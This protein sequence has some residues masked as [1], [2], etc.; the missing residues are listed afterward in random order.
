VRRLT[1]NLRRVGFQ[2]ASTTFV[3]PETISQLHSSWD[4]LVKP[5]NSPTWEFLW[6]SK[7]DE[8]REKGLL[9]TAFTIDSNHVPTFRNDLSN[10]QEVQV[11]E[12][13]LKVRT[14]SPPYSRALLTW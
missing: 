7:V 9:Q 11:A 4:V 6:E 10:N 13:A 5:D 8:S 12:A 1:N 14:T 2:E 3:L